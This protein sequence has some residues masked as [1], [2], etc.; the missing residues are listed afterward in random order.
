[1]LKTSVGGA[2]RFANPVVMAFPSGDDDSP[3]VVPAVVLVSVLVVV[4][5]VVP[6]GHPPVVAPAVE[7]VC[8]AVP[9][10]A[11]AVAGLAHRGGE[12]LATTLTPIGKTLYQSALFRLAS[13]GFVELRLICFG[14]GV[15]A[16][17]V[18]MERG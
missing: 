9:A 16:D 12:H 5:A 15:L 3:A 6:V 17:R 10:V 18:L 7:V 13:S 4:V 8:G 11:V 14:L 1:M 2:H